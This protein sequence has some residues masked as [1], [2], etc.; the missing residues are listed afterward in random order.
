M[1][2]S[3]FLKRYKYLNNTESITPGCARKTENLPIFREKLRNP[4]GLQ[5]IEVLVNLDT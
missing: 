4:A 3:D 2:F 1:N 5:F